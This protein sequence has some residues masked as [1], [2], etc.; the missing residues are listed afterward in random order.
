MSDPVVELSE[1]QR[2]MLGGV[3]ARIERI[4]FETRANRF[5]PPALPELEHAAEQMKRDT[6][7]LVPPRRDDLPPLL[8]ELY[9]LI[10][11]MSPR[12]LRAYG[13]VSEEVAAYIED[14]T[15]RLEQLAGELID[16]AKNRARTS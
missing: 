9:V 11:E 4:L 14:A 16:A 1:A 12:G 5:E 10:G 13:D 6:A 7:A 8:A 15:G 2:R 3:F